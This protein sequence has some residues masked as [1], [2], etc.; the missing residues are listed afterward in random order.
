[1]F[2][3]R[4]PFALDERRL[5]A[6]VARAH[7]PRRGRLVADDERNLRAGHMSVAHGVNEREHVRPAAR[8]EDADF[9]RI[10]GSGVRVSTS[11]GSGR[12]L[13]SHAKTLPLP[14]EVLTRSLYNDS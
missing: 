7:A 1:M 4:A 3:A 14:R 8:N 11:R 10:F 6:T 12:V 9:H 13:A 2:F 5:D